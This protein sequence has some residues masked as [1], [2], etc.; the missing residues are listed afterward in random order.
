[1]QDA[2]L[3]EL[4]LRVGHISDGVVSALILILILILLLVTA[5]VLACGFFRVCF[6]RPLRTV[7]PASAASAREKKPHS[8]TAFPHHI[9]RLY[10][11]S[12][13]KRMKNFAFMPLVGIFL[14]LNF[15]SCLIGDLCTFCVRVCAHA[16]PG[17]VVF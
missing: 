4:L 15:I 14:L 13:P 12:N 2:L 10:A 9:H 11:S 8:L 17:L 3:R 1:M 16:C 6:V 5:S 7:L